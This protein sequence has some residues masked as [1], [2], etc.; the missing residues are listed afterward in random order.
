MTKYLKIQSKG[1]IETNAFTLIGASSKRNDS[2]KIGY[3]GSGLKYSISALIR[4]NISFKVYQGINEIKFTTQG[5]TFRDETYAKILV[6]GT[7]TSL[8]T[9]MGGKDWDIPFAPIRE[10]YSNAL[11]EDEDASIYEALSFDNGGEEGRTTFFI[12]MTNDVKHFYENI[13]LYFCIKNPN[14]LSV[15]RYGSI[16]PNNDNDSFRLFRKGILCYKGENKKSLFNYNLNSIDINE[17]RVIQSLY[18]GKI[19]SAMVLKECTNKSVILSVIKGLEGGNSG[20]FEHTF[21][22]DLSQKFSAE[23]GEVCAKFKYLPVELMMFVD[24]DVSTR[25]KLPLELLKILKREFPDLDVLGLN[26][27]TNDGTGFIKTESPSEILTDKVIDALA[28]LN[29]TRYKHRLESPIIEYGN[30]T[31]ENVLGMASNGKILLSVKLD[32]YDVPAIAKIII[33]ENEHLKSG[34]GDK[35]RQF[36]DHLFNLYYDELTSKSKSNEQIISL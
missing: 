9:G 13:G 30:F 11:D 34:F 1:E 32:T 28:S 24:E 23:W 19:A 10:I 25:M 17:A 21:D 12:E 18:S 16:Y 29:S 6:N 35:T 3:F 31:K 2:S 26:E 5:V 15:G 7:E 8:T 27:K 33:E 4:N 20:F 36:Q 22:W 14:V